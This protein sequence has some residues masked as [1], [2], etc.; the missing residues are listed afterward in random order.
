MNPRFVFWCGVLLMSMLVMVKP[1]R[2]SVEQVAPT[3][4]ALFYLNGHPERPWNT[5]EQACGDNAVYGGSPASIYSYSGTTIPNSI[6]ATC[7]NWWDV[8]IGSPICPV[9][10]SGAVYAYNYTTRMCER[11]LPDCPSAGTVAASGTFDIGTNP[12]WPAPG[13]LSGC[14]VNNCETTVAS[15]DPVS[16][17]GKV[18]GVYHYYAQGVLTFTGASCTMGIPVAP[19]VVNPATITQTC[20]AG[21]VGVMSTGGVLNCYKDG[22]IQG[23]SAPVATT[24]STAI[25]TTTTIDQASGASSVSETTTQTTTQTT[26]SGGTYMPGVASDLQD[27]CSRNPSAQICKPA[28]E[29]TFTAPGGN[30]DVSQNWYTKR[31]P[32]GLS[33]VIIDRTNQLKAT[34]LG[35]MINGFGLSVS[36]AASNGCFSMPGNLGIVDFGA[37]QFCIPQGVLTFI[38]IIMMLTAVF[39]SRVIIFGG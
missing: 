33:G 25:S 5:P 9:P 35:S 6:Y 12:D 20:A 13:V 21:E 37:M 28:N 27:Y 22:L 14:G 8:R 4:P 16:A 10:E 29:P 19:A 11:T 7:T 31:F 30:P 3:N 34:P 23:A 39:T 38:G 18:G 15:L 26:G 24:T 36:A 2:A 17:R 32:N 1:V